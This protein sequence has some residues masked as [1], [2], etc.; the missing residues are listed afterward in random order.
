MADLMRPIPFGELL[1]RIMG[2]FRNHDSIF[3]IDKA[4]FYKDDRK[5]TVNV[6]SQS[7]TTPMGP[8]A[9]PHTQLSQ[10]I[11]ASYLV[12]ARFIELKTVQ[13]MDHLEIA[14]PCIDARDEGY[15]VEW[16]TEY[17]LEKAYDEY[18]KAWIVL[19]MIES[20]ME[21]K[22]VE[23]PSFI[24][25]MSCGYNLEGIKQEKMQIFIDSM[26]DA[27]KKP[28]FD[29]YINEAKALLD[30]G[31]LEG[32][33]WEGREECVR[34]TLDKISK[35][36]CPS[37]TVS[38]MHGCPPKEIEAICS[39]LLTEKKLDTFVKLNPTLLG[40]DTVRKVLDDLGFNYVVL[41]RESFEHDLQLSDAKA[42]LH[43]LVELAGKEG[44]KFGV[45]LT[46]TLGNVNPQ[47]VLPGDE[48]YGSGRILLPLSTRV[49]LILSEEFNG[50][51]PISYSG[52]V[53]ALSVK[54]LFEIGIHPI[55]LATDMLHP[56]G[57]AKMKQLCEICK[58]APE[59]WK[60]ETID[61][62][63]LRKFV[64]TV[65][66]PKGIAGKEF[67]GTNSSK[68][69]TPLS[70]FDCYVAPCVEACP[71]HQPIPEY[72][73]L[74]GE[75]RLAEAL[76]LIY[77]SNA[78][79]NITG[80]ICDHQCQNHCTRMDYEGPVQIREVKRI[81]A[82]KGFDEFKASMWE[83]PDEP[84]DVKAAVIGAGP[85]GLAAAYFLALA[86]FDTSVFEKEKNAGGVVA[87]I[88]P[89]FRIPLE[90]VEKDVQ[91]I[92]DN[93][94]KFNFGTEKTIKELRD[95]GFEYIFV[96][97][98]ATASND[99]HVSGNGPRES[100]ISFLLRSK[101]GEKIDLGKNVV[102]VGGGN[103]AMDAARMAI[104]TQGVESVTVVYRRSQ[105]EMPADREEYEMALS[106]GVKFL[107]LANP[108][109][110]TDGIMNVK[111]MV[112]GE[113]DASGR[114]KPVESGETFSLD[115][116]YMISAI[117]EKADQNV[118]DA[119][120]V[121]EEGKV[122]IIGDTKTGPSTVVRCIAS[123]QSAVDDA[124]DKVY[125]DILS[126][127]DDEKECDCEGECT[128]SSQEEEVIEED[129]DID[130]IRSEEDDFFASIREKKSSVLLSASK[131]S[132]DFLKTEAK[133]CLECSYYC[134]KCTE[135]CPNR[136]NVMLDMRDTGL[137]DDPF[138]ILH[139]DAYCNECGNCAA[140][141]P[142]DGGPYLKKFTLFSR[143]DDF[144]N[145]TNSGFYCEN[146]Q[147]KIRLD[148]KIIDGEIDKDGKLV[149]DVP[150][151]VKAM[152]ET[153]FV[154]YSYLLGPVEE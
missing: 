32:S 140:F 75:G 110:V 100:A 65:S 74:A 76:S 98:G 114:R 31:I 30:D 11:V 38:T 14:K 12:G 123:A 152:V 49:A 132:K 142:H 91:F 53:S 92:K 63:R 8:A 73:A 133:R 78:L 153:V 42:M 134:N 104:R 126:Q 13:I 64:E 87:N 93:G 50:T 120:G 16:S 25:N 2:E 48:R 59:A 108:S 1:T 57:Y 28:L 20:A 139:L 82:E 136:A 154:S 86:G 46:N 141:C 83:K 7:C 39:Y 10:N 144:E 18:L 117:G 29:E 122:Y 56:G 121:G 150:E 21:G 40:Y 81:A 99:P 67:R 106:D 109:D 101:N 129:E 3:S 90:A 105:S 68:V 151:E 23:K 6:F 128:C 124:I 9:G 58:E 37:V 15:N 97:V 125:E 88:I 115:C 111:K 17:T 19:H 51:L 96:G 35:N 62:S 89:E 33:D 102:V 43:R 147:V 5:K 77:T 71:I 41:K 36:I 149:A 52:G 22:V 61:V 26:I 60:K 55:T 44:R 119:I 27:G 131:T 116:S 137:F 69:G 107:F 47:D 94:V 66:S 84:A 138:Q 112:L 34:K 80:W 146:D 118:L 4:Q 143:P 85:A 127:D 145:S 72:V 95:E 24:F 130:E 79:P 113:K 54:E 70:L 148:G 45:K 135:V 103:T